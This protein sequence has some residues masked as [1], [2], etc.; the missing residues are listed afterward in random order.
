MASTG[1]TVFFR[2][3]EPRGLRRPFVLFGLITI[4]GLVIVGAGVGIEPNLN[5]MRI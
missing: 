1:P 2:G 4:K 3:E 5:I